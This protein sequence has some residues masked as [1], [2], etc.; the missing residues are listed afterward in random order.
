MYGIPPCASGGIGGTDPEG[1][2]GGIHPQPPR[3]GNGDR[4]SRA[5]PHDIAPRR[6][7][8]TIPWIWVFHVGEPF[9]YPV[10]R[11][12]RGFLEFGIVQSCGIVIRKIEA[13]K[14]V[15]S[16]PYQEERGTKCRGGPLVGGAGVLSGEDQR[17]GAPR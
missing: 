8:I 7:T 15:C 6:I 3:D 4:K 1:R 11:R 16:L 9:G 5:L 2:G 10:A 12:P 14:P 13:S 17:R